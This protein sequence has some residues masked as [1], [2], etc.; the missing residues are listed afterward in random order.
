MG[1]TAVDEPVTASTPSTGAPLGEDAE[2]AIVL[3]CDTW[4]REGFAAALLGRET[5][6]DDGDGSTV[7][8]AIMYHPWPIGPSANTYV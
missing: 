3:V 7:G 5:A 6:T 2:A 8:P 4:I 1:V